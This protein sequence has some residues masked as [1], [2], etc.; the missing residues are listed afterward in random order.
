MG[1]L[2]IKAIIVHKSWLD[3]C[4]MVDTVLQ[5][6]G[7]ISVI[8]WLLFPPWSA[9]LGLDKV[10]AIVFVF[11]GMCTISKLY[12]CRS[13]C[14]RAVLLFRFLR[15]FQYVRLAWSVRIVNGSFVQPRHGHQWCKLFITARSSCL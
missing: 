12:S 7:G 13:V 8:F 5:C 11:P 9:S 1:W 14:H 3:G 10:S 4:S 2:C 15:A 6:V